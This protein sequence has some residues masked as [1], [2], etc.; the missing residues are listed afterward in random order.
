LNEIQQ[1]LVK[2]TA[3]ALARQMAE[4]SGHNQG[5]NTGSVVPNAVQNNVQ[6]RKA[7]D[8]LPRTATVQRDE[9]H[10]QPSNTTNATDAL[11]AVVGINKQVSQNISESDHLAGDNA[12]GGGRKRD[13]LVIVVESLDIV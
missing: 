12:A 13:R 3:E 9:V 7:N 11:L 8:V 4:V 2:E 6:V 1:Q 5:L 10:I